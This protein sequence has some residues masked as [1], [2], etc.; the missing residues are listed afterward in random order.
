MLDDRAEIA[1]RRAAAPVEFFLNVGGR[2][3]QDV[4]VPLSGRK[5]HEGMRRVLRR[6]RAAV[7][8]DCSK[9]L[10]GPKE[11]FVRDDFLGGRILFRPDSELHW[12]A[13]DV[14]KTVGL[15]LMF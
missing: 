15:A 4:A 7:H 13:E 1:A 6:M 3:G 10:V 14:G 5:P 9:L 8:P 2:H 12:P 11:L